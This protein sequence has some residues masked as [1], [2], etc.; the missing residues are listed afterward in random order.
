VLQRFYGDEISEQNCKTQFPLLRIKTV[1]A[2][3]HV[4]LW[5]SFCVVSRDKYILKLCCRNFV[6]EKLRK[7]HRFVLFINHQIDKIHK[8]LMRQDMP[9][10][11][12]VYLNE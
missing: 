12:V 9:S 2:P 7:K 8:Q 6:E 4:I 11:V 5:Q 1:D 10:F 3:K